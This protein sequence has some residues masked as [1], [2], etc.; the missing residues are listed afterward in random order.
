MSKAVLCGGVTELMA[1]GW[2]TL[3]EAGY[4]PEVAYFECLHEMK[5]IIDL[6]YEGGFARMH[7]FV[8]E[9]AKYGDLTRGPRVVDEHAKEQMK[10]VLEEIQ[11]GEFAREW[12]EENKTGRKNYNTLLEADLKHPV[13]EVGE[14]LRSQMAWIQEAKAK[15]KQTACSSLP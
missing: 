1:K 9:T 8:S 12:I 2:E 15:Q 5:L 6:I 14:K 3:V 10:K 13:E 7:E 4:Q 11:K